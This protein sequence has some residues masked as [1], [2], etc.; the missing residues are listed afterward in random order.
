MFNFTRVF[1]CPFLPIKAMG[2]ERVFQGEKN[3]S[4][5]RKLGEKSAVFCGDDGS[6]WVVFLLIDFINQETP[7][8]YRFGRC[9]LRP[10]E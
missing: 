9:E 1:Y 8:N 2:C 5:Q 10:V 3:I 7:E 6:W 4:I